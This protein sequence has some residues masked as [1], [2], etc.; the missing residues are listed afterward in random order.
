MET[1]IRDE[2]TINEIVTLIVKYPD[3]FFIG[4]G[5]DYA[6]SLEG[7]L[8]LKRSPTSTRRLTQQVN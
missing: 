8:K 1:M 6:F 5:M 7:A 2:N 3:V 4:R